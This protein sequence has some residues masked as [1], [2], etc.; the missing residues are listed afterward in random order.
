MKVSQIY[1]GTY[2]SGA[3]LAG[4]THQLAIE[5]VGV[6]EVG[7]EREQKLV[8]AFVGARKSLVLNKTNAMRAR[9]CLRRRY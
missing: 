8:V 4:K 9:Q 1:G 2:L 3:D 7:E 5:A 6:E